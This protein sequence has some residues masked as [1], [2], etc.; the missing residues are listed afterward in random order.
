MAGPPVLL[1]HKVEFKQPVLTIVRQPQK[2]GYRFRYASE[3]LTH[4]GIRG[5]LSEGEREEKVFP[6]FKISGYRGRA[7]V[8]LTIVTENKANEETFLHAHSLVVDRQETNGYHIFDVDGSDPTKEMTTVAIQHVE[9]RQQ[10]A[11]LMDR[12]LQTQF[13]KK[14]G[15]SNMHPGAEQFY[16]LD[17]FT[18]ALKDRDESS[19][20]G[21]IDRVRNTDVTAQEL[22]ALEAQAKSLAK[23]MDMTKC[24]LCFQA[25]CQDSVTGLYSRRLD[26]VYSDVIYDGKTA[27]GAQ[28]KIQRISKVVSPVCGQEEVWIIGDRLNPDDI[29]VRF[30]FLNSQHTVQYIGNKGNIG[31]KVHTNNDPFVKSEF[32]SK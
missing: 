1:K 8:V 14:Y 31:N 29:Q 26:P 17:A 4:G 25:F 32:S 6:S 23:K 30:C 2:R 3:G 20:S 27:Q 9:K 5:E 21:Y 15:W 12:I 11:K 7:K 10:E 28:L 16:D 24:R 18:K 13:L 19:E 22:K